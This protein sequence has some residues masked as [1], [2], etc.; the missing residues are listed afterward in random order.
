MLKKMI[1]GLMTV[2]V[3]AFS[4]SACSEKKMANDAFTIWV[5]TSYKWKY[6]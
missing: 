1:F 4:W 5:L 3:L 2:G 6:N